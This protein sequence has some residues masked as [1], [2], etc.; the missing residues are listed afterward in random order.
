MKNIGKIFLKKGGRSLKGGDTMTITLRNGEKRYSINDVDVVNFISD[1][2]NKKEIYFLID[3]RI[4]IFFI[5]SCF[6]KFLFD[7]YMLFYNFYSFIF[8]LFF[9]FFIIIYL[10]VYIFNIIYYYY[11][12]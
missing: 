8:F 4:L 6:F 9:P 3:I 2:A 11:I 5:Y 10:F 12:I 1:T 7:K